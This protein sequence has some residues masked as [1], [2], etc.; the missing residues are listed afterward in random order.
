MS[1]A[2]VT[3]AVKAKLY[4]D[5]RQVVN[6][7]TYV[8]TTKKDMWKQCVVKNVDTYLAHRHVLLQTA[9]T[10]IGCQMMSVQWNETAAEPVISSVVVMTVDTTNAVIKVSDT[11]LQNL[12]NTLLQSITVTEVVRFDCRES[13]TSAIELLVRDKLNAHT[14]FITDNCRC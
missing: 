1:C 6:N 2:I 8:R 13:K 7:A 10:S 5:A 9:F 4:Y 3:A 11:S 12:F 14:L